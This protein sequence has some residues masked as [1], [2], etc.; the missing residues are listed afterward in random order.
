M[1]IVQSTHEVKGQ[2]VKINIELDKVVVTESPYGP[3]RGISSAEKVVE[4]ARDYF[5]EAVELAKNCASS[6]AANLQSLGKTSRPNEIQVQLAIKI[7]AEAGAVL[8][9]LGAE[10][11][12]QV[13]M[14]WTAKETK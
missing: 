8:T 3:T 11:Q 7:D 13:T 14:K 6:L 4:A 9:K 10:A 5:G 1:S 2:K 12:L